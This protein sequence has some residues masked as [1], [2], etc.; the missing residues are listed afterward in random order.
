MIWQEGYKSKAQR[1]R[2]RAEIWDMIKAILFLVG[3]LAVIL[4]SIAHNVA[5]E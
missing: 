5:F 3:M 1:A 4:L 2:E